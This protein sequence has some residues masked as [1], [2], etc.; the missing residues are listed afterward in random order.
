MYIQALIVNAFLILFIP[1]LLS[2]PTGIQVVDEFVTYLRAQQTFLVSSSLL[3][4]IVIYATQYWIEHSA[5]NSG[6]TS[7]IRSFVKE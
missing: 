2:R 3:L 5:E 6:P 4:A 7:P 1:R